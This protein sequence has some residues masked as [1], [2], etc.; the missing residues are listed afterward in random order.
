MSKNDKK[1]PPNKIEIEE[2]AKKFMEAKRSGVENTDFGLREYYA[3]QA[4]AGL[5]SRSQGLLRMSEIKR[6]A[7]E[8]ADFMLEE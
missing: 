2:E 4:L 1:K 8:W 5:L 3:G 6:E 7:F